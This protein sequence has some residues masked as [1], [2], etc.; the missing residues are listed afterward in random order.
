MCICICINVYDR[1]TTNMLASMERLR[2]VGEQM[3]FYF[4]FIFEYSLSVI[5][6]E[7][8]LLV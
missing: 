2:L 8:T 1:M 7:N 3:T 4:F 6:N 5:Y